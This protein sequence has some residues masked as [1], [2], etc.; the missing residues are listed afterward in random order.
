MFQ[1]LQLGL[2]DKYLEVIDKAVMNIARRVIVEGIVFKLSLCSKII[3]FLRGA[4]SYLTG[5]WFIRCH[6]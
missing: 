6:P 3:L 1:P 5:P 2:V 4:V